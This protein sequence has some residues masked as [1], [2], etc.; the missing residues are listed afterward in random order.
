MVLGHCLDPIRGTG[1]FRHK[2][3]GRT[4]G[5]PRWVPLIE[6]RL[7]VVDSVNRDQAKYGGLSALRTREFRANWSESYGIEFVREH[8]SVY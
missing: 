6:N 7:P 2:P 3:H 4:S 5:Q 1:E 8:N